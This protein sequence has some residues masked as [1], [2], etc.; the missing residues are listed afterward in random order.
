MVYFLIIAELC[1]IAPLSVFYVVLHNEKYEHFPLKIFSKMLRYAV[2]FYIVAVAAAVFSHV[3]LVWDF[4][5]IVGI[6]AHTAFNFVAGMA[7]VLSL[8]KFSDIP[9]MYTKQ[10][11]IARS[12]LYFAFVFEVMALCAFVICCVMFF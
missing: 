6:T 11:L 5:C 3:G 8:I 2:M 7:L 10:Y 9:L 4:H 1:V 12:A